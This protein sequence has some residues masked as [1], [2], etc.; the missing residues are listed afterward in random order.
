MQDTAGMIIQLVKDA[1]C[2]GATNLGKSKNA[3]EL[4]IAILGSFTQMHAKLNDNSKIEELTSE[5]DV[6][7][8]EFFN[9]YCSIN[10]VISSSHQPIAIDGCYIKPHIARLLAHPEILKLVNE[11]CPFGLEQ[12][13]L[14]NLKPKHFYP[15]VAD[16]MMHILKGVKLSYRKQKKVEIAIEV[17]TELAI[18]QIYEAGEEFTEKSIEPFIVKTLEDV[19]EAVYTYG[20]GNC[21]LMADAAFLWAIQENTGESVHYLRIHCD[22]NKKVDVIN[23][24]AI[25]PWPEPG[26]TLMIPWGGHG[27]ITWNGSIAKTPALT[28]IHPSY[29]N[30]LKICSLSPDMQE[31]YQSLLEER[32]FKGFKDLPIR[33]H[34]HHTIKQL[35]EKLLE[36]LQAQLLTSQPLTRTEHKINK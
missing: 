30:I 32:S 8:C 35:S 3:N 15:I 5:E 14:D 9:K 19:K 10:Q 11:H 21:S 1:C 22:E 13:K 28:K 4:W 18:M 17:L 25:G 20:F 36:Q 7:L 2:H 34:M 29:N 6:K 27:V 24:V 26:C 16:E 23:L 31:Q 33:T 12:Q